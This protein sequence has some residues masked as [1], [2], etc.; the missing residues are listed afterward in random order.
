[1]KDAIN[2]LKKS[3]ESCQSHRLH[4]ETEIKQLEGELSYKRDELR[5]FLIR[6]AE[7]QSAILKLEGSSDVKSKNKK[8]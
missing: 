8:A 6:E 5:A 3:I 7:L 2:I 4:I 1:M